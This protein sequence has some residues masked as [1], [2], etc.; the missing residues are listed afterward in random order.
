MK[1]KL[2]VQV[3]P[4]FVWKM[5]WRDSRSSRRRLFVFSISITLGIAALVSIGTR[6]TFHDDAA[7][8]VEVHLLDFDGDLYGK[9]L[10]VELVARLRDERRFADADSLVVQMR[11]DAEAG[12]AVLGMR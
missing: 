7:V 9:L 4:G 3:A 1:Q 5:A 11:R 8:L 6:P 10:G 2:N 12:R